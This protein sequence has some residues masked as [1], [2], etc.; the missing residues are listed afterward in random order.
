MKKYFRHK[1]EN[2]LVIDKIVTI[3]YFEFGKNFVSE[4]E[5]HDFWELV[6]ADKGGIVCTAGENTVP[7]G[8]GEMIFHKPNEFHRLAADG[9]SVPNIF[10][11]SFECKSEAVRF[12]ENKKI[13]T[14]KGSR[15][16][17]YAIWEEA[18][19]TFDIP[20]SDPALKKLKLL[21]SPTLGG[22]QLIRNYLE[23]LLI[24]LMRS[25]TETEGGN[26]VFLQKDEFENKPVKDILKILS[27]NVE[28]RLTVN[29]ICAAAGYSRAYAFRAFKTA[30]GKS[31]MDYFLH[32]KI[33]RAKQ[34][35]REGEFSVKEIADALAFDTPNY[36]S[37][38]FKRIEG[39]TPS[40][41]KKRS[42]EMTAA[43][44]R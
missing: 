9:K 42:S 30:T 5:S 41:Y 3:H 22:Q 19:K 1:L 36:F 35:L 13:R 16:L 32:L 14:E 29:D 38:S 10:I 17:I 7:L 43:L 6:Y 20:F 28:S 39:I 15:R 8:Q 12:F 2:L 25:Q 18:K 31:I 26:R 44:S 40:A 4:G 37:K 21:P 34:L 23:I 11:V 27:E 33:E 24:D